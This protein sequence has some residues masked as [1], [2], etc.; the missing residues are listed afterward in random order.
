MACSKCGQKKAAANNVQPAT[1][2]DKMSPKVAVSQRSNPLGQNFI[3]RRYIGESGIVN[4]VLANMTY[5]NR[6]KGEI[7]TIAEVEVTTNP[8]Q[9]QE[10]DAPWTD[11]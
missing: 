2:N 3:T 7:L 4:S 9:W 10:V 11:E 1:V 8:D 6:K 5:G